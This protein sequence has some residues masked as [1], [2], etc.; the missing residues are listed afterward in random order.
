MAKV[1]ETMMLNSPSSILSIG[2][3]TASLCGE[4]SESLE[5]V[6]IDQSIYMIFIAKLGNLCGK[7]GYDE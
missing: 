1:K 7:G 5:V 6:G 3:G 2:C 4:L